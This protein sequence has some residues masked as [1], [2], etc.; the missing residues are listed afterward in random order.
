[1]SNFNHTF[2]RSTRRSRPG[3]PATSV[4]LRISL[5]IVFFWFGFLKFFPP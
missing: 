1:M 2:D 3:W 4:T 5:G